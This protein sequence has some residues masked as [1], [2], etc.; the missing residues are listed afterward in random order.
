MEAQTEVNRQI[1]ARLDSLDDRVRKLERYIWIAFG[2][3][4]VLQF[5]V[6]IILGHV[7]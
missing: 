4:G 5:A 3:L 1:L 2:A 7:K 6:P